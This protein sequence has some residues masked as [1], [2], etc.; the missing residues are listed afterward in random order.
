M[1]ATRV[2]SDGNVVCP[3]CGAKNSFTVKR[4][5]KAKL[6]GGLAVGV[7]ALAA[8]KRLKCNGCGTNLKR[9]SA[10]PA[11]TT[12]RPHATRGPGYRCEKNDHLLKKGR[13]T[14]PIDGSPVT[15]RPARPTT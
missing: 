14:C 8:P 13:T 2:D 7:G 11:R 9:S 3:K 1:K 6:M 5:G 12:A 15:Y 10:P 4:T